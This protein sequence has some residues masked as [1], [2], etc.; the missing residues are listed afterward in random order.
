MK[1]V[2]SE[3]R[4][5]KRLFP[6]TATMYMEQLGMEIHVC[7]SSSPGIPIMGYQMSVRL[8]HFEEV[9]IF[10]SVL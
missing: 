9:V 6:T 2:L 3:D 4:N 8:A 10:Y 7:A 5:S 1:T